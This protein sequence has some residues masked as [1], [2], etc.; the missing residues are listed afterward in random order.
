MVL[1][2]LLV[3]PDRMLD[4]KTKEPLTHYPMISATCRN[5]RKECAA[6]LY[7]EN[8]LMI[9]IQ[10]E[11]SHIVSLFRPDDLIASVPALSQGQLVRISSGTSTLGTATSTRRFASNFNKF[12]LEVFPNNQRHTFDAMWHLLPDLQGLFHGSKIHLH[13]NPINGSDPNVRVHQERWAQVFMIICCTKIKVSGTT[14]QVAAEVEAV[15]ASGKARPNLQQSLTRMK[16]MLIHFSVQWDNAYRRMADRLDQELSNARD[17]FDVARFVA[18][19]REV[20]VA[21][22]TMN[23]REVTRVET[24]LG[25]L[26]ESIQI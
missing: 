7:R 25:K 9:R 5:L 17:T 26:E 13:L 19:S 12:Y 6:I 4:E 2:D 18:A 22:E 3:A 1:R 10:I 15:I 21:F 11:S 24:M 20:M 14:K 16:G 23:A 8:C